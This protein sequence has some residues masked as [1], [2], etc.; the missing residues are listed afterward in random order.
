MASGNEDLHGS[1]PDKAGIALIL[2]DVINDLEFPE[3]DELLRHAL[4]MAQKLAE[5]KRRA[6]RVHI[7]VVYANNNF[8]RWQSNFIQDGLTAS[9]TRASSPGL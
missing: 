8:G 2:I 6:K 9:A 3:G 1:A 7:P 4:P 5:L